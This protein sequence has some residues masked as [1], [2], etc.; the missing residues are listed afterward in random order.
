M[1]PRLATVLLDY[2]IDRQCQAQLL[3]IDEHQVRRLSSTI[4]SMNPSVYQWPKKSDPR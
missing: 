1:L 3:D 2:L 4:D